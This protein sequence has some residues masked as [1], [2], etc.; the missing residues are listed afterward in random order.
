MNSI[1]LT[2]RLTRDPELKYLPSGDPVAQFTLAVDRKYKKGEAD[3][4]NIVA[5]GKQAEPICTY[6]A[7]GRKAGVV[8]RL[9]IRTHEKDGKRQYYTE[10]V[11]DEVEFL[12]SK[13]P[14]DTPQDA[15]TEDVPF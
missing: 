13:T 15:P 4:I 12:D 8:G 5:F 2:G 10:V 11:A 9:Q 7:K 6:L 14:Q 3:F 1:T